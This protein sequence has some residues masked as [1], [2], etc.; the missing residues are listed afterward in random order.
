ML[1]I[2]EQ[3]NPIPTAACGSLVSFSSFME[4]RARRGAQTRAQD[5][6]LLDPV[7]LAKQP[8]ILHRLHTILSDEAP[9][10]SRARSGRGG[11]ALAVCK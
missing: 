8:G 6:A 9:S 1:M 2:R 10:T 3:Q 7:D 11:A 5:A 4:A